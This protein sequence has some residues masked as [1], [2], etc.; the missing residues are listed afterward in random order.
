MQ[1]IRR[2]RSNKKMN[3]AKTIPTIPPAVTRRYAR[4]KMLA[5]VH[6]PFWQS[7]D[8]HCSWRSHFWSR[9]PLLLHNPPKE[10]TWVPAQSALEVQLR[11]TQKPDSAHTCPIR[12]SPP[13]EHG[14]LAQRY[15]PPEASRQYRGSAHSK[16]ALHDANSLFTPYFNTAWG[17]PDAI[18]TTNTVNVIENRAAISVLCY[19]NYVPP[20]QWCRKRCRSCRYITVKDALPVF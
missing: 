10:Q 9:V 20:V 12:Q 17:D 2:S 11:R 18:P 8:Q 3:A 5:P 14:F 4:S 7:S 13:P 19:A 1:K 15:A 6:R 16:G